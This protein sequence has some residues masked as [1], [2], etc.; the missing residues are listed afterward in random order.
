VKRRQF[1]AGL[2]CVAAGPIAVRGQ[3]P[4]M[5]TIGFLSSASPRL[6]ADFD[7]AFRAGLMEYGFEPGLNVTIEFAWAEGELA[8]LPVLAAELVRQQVAVITTTGAPAA[9]AAKSATATIPIAFI[10]GDDPVRFGLVASFA[11]PGNWCQ[12]SNCNLGRQKT[13][14]A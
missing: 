6:Y 14:G 13:R 3:Q 5:P 12:L 8:R 4:A 7:P 9:L 2:A 11:R 10:T 1:I